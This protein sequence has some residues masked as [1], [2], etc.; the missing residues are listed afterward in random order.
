V[1][2][3]VSLGGDADTQACIAGAV[4][5][6]RWGVPDEVDSRARGHLPAHLLEIV[7]D[8]EARLAGEDA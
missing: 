3:A 8:F 2:L 4:A 1:R 5:Q 6:A 7:V